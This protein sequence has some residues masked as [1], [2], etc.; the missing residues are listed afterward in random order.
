MSVRMRWWPA[1]QRGFSPE[2]VVIDGDNMT[3]VPFTDLSWQWRQIEAAVMPRLRQLMSSSA[4]CLGPYVEEFER[5]FASYCGVEHAIG[6][7]NG[8]SALHLA[9]IAAGIGPGDQVL[10][11]AD[12]FIATAWAVLYV[13]ALPVFCDV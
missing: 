7:N 11:P 2:P 13:G 10:V 8:T 9:L 1:F 4:F 12:T 3:P 6:V 5:A